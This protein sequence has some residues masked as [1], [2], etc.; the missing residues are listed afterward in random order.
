MG[1]AAK[2]DG[3][4]QT[5]LAADSDRPFPRT[6]GL[7]ATALEAAI[8]LL[9][10]E[11]WDSVTQPKVAERSGLGRATIYRYWPDRTAL[12]HD[13]VLTH[14]EV[15]E[16][17]PPS[18]DLRQDLIR[19][20]NH[21]RRELTERDLGP[22]LAALVDRA[23]WGPD[24]HRLKLQIA[25]TGASIVRALLRDAIG[26]GELVPDTNVEASISILVGPLLFRRLISGE[27]NSPEFVGW[28]V[29]SY[30]TAHGVR[31]QRSRRPAS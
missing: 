18:G 29:D 10:E 17:P 5:L 23:E 2:A 25:E 6:D 14:M 4:A 24:L 16:H 8:A 27:T 26:R 11:G 21:L 7:R 28:L 3:M 12:V 19:E 20:L 22:V 9:T 1:P 13:A 15:S 30:L 31:R